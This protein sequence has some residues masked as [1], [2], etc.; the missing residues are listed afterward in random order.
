MPLVSKPLRDRAAR[1]RNMARSLSDLQALKAMDELAFD[2]KR[3]AEQLYT[4]HSINRSTAEAET[5]ARSH[6][7]HPA[8]GTQP[9]PDHRS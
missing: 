4:E 7:P 3:R 5:N 8:S 6:D 2:L 9:R 1:L